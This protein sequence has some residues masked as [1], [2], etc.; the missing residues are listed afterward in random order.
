MKKFPDKTS[1]VEC[2]PRLFQQMA[3]DI[4]RNC[5][6]Q[7]NDNLL[8]NIYHPSLTIFIPY[9]NASDLSGEFITQEIEKVLQSNEDFRI[10][11]G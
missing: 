6:A 1:P 8:M 3:D 7:E 11:D 2:I 5:E 9:T 4:K 10:N